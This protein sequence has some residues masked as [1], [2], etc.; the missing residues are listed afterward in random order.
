[1]WLKVLLVKIYWKERGKSIFADIAGILFFI[2][3]GL[4]NIYYAELYIINKKSLLV[5]FSYIS[6]F[7]TNILFFY[8]LIEE[9]FSSI[10]FIVKHQ[11]F[12]TTL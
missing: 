5:N 11:W 2:Y 9:K 8:G 3:I 7:F 1:M 6:P 12:K 10:R 4:H